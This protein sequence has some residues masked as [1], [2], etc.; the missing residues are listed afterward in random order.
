[1]GITLVLKHTEGVVDCVCFEKPERQYQETLNKLLADCDK[2]NGYVCV[3]LDKPYKPRTTGEGSQNNLFWFL[4]TA[5]AKHTGSDIDEVEQ[6]LKD[7]AINRGYPYHINSVSHK[8]TGDSMTT[9]NTVQMSYLIDV[10]YEEIAEQGIVLPPMYAKKPEL[11]EPKTVDTNKIAE[12]ALE[13]E[14]E[15]YDIF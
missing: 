8:P 4:A 9:V 10:A 13:E 11:F 2:N 3:T 14:E 12:E 5:I 7:K 1:M 6:G 15:E